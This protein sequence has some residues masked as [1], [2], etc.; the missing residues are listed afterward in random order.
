MDNLES[1][2]YEIFEKDP[3]KYTEYQKVRNCFT[4]ICVVS[5]LIFIFGSGV[6]KGEGPRGPDR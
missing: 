6:A 5:K 1:S 3:T 2:T 4:F